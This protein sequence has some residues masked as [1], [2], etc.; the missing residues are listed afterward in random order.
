M[1][2]L[3]QR[4][5]NDYHSL[6]ISCRSLEFIRWGLRWCMTPLRL[7]LKVNSMQRAQ[8]TQYTPENSLEVP[9][10]GAGL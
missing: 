3:Q 10:W 2:D 5:F 1:Q 9:F 7:V 6:I 8:Y 4:L